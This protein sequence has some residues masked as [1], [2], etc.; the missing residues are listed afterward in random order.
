MVWKEGWNVCL[1]CASVVAILTYPCDQHQVFPERSE[2][3][4]FLDD[5]KYYTLPG[6]VLTDLLLHT[7][8]PPSLSSSISFRFLHTEV[9]YTTHKLCQRHTIVTR[10]TQTQL[11]SCFLLLLLRQLSFTL[12]CL[13]KPVFSPLLHLF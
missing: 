7:R 5:H 3:L 11:G 4:D 12:D 6:A 8:H 10:L 1:V 9:S 2:A 13:I